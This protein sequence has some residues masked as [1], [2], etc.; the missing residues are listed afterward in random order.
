MAPMATN[1][2]LPVSANLAWAGS[3]LGVDVGLPAAADNDGACVVSAGV[4]EVAG[5]G[6]AVV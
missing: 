2:P 4:A 3:M 5:A 1:I 6:A